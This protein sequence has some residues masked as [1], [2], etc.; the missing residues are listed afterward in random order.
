MR[1]NRDVRVGYLLAT[2][3][4]EFANQPPGTGGELTDVAVAYLDADG[5][6]WGKSIAAPSGT[7]SEDCVLDEITWPH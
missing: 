7:P 4:V 2:R 6:F 1:G 3:L 5:L